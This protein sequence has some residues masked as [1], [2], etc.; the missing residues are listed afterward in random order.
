VEA[1]EAVRQK[2]W[3]ADSKGVCGTWNQKEA[4]GKAQA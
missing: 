3:L 2:H 1:S 4:E